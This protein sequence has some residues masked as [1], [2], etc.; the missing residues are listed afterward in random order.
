MNLLHSKLQN[1]ISVETMDK[2]CF[3]Y[4]NVRSLRHSSDW[5]QWECS[6]TE[7][8]DLLLSLE[9]NLVGEVNADPWGNE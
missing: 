9:D 7:V 8:E 6:T 3:I 4:I 2:L 1:R 5:D